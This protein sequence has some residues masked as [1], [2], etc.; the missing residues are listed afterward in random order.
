MNSFF[1]GLPLNMSHMHEEI[2]MTYENKFVCNVPVFS[3]HRNIYDYMPWVKLWCLRRSEGICHQ[4]TVLW[5][6]LCWCVELCT[7]CDTKLQLQDI[8]PVQ[9]LSLGNWSLCMFL[10]STSSCINVLMHV[11]NV[12]LWPMWMYNASQVPPTDCAIT[13]L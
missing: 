1:D 12:L 8:K 7:S 6:H 3:I 4:S 5:S 11:Y 9:I 13:V 2:H 10:I